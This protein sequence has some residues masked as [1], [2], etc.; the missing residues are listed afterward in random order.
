MADLDTLG[1]AGRTAREDQVRVGILALCRMQLMA[2]SGYARNS[3]RIKRHYNAAAE[4][5]SIATITHR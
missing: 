3:K 5:C 1:L 2:S 4:M